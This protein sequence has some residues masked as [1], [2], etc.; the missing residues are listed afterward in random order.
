MVKF[1]RIQNNKKYTWAHKYIVPDTERHLEMQGHSKTYKLLGK[2]VHPTF[3]CAKAL[4][5][6]LLVEY[7]IKEN[8]NIWYHIN[9]S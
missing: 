5:R 6:K 2:K 4:Q 7:L 8:Y 3:K 1:A 9:I